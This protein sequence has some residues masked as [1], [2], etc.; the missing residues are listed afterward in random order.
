MNPSSPASPGTKAIMV[1]EPPSK[2]KAH[3][4]VWGRM[5]KAVLWTITKVVLWPAPTLAA[6][7]L[8]IAYQVP[9]AGFLAVAAGSF[10]LAV[11]S[12]R[13]QIAKDLRKWRN[14][15][16]TKW[17][18]AKARYKSAVEKTYNEMQGQ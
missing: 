12:V 2:T 4:V 15:I 16:R 13:K 7:G 9:G 8:L 14:N 3:L 1:K 5:G 10:N 18:Q 6:A 17:Q 11:W